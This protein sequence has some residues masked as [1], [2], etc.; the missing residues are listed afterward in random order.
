LYLFIFES[1]G[2]SELILIAIVSLI[3]LGPRKMPQMARKIGKMMSDFRNATSEFKTTWEREVNFED[4]T[5]AFRTGTIDDE[6]KP[7]PRVDSIAAPAP[8]DA[9]AS[10]EVTEVDPA[11][12]DQ[13]RVSET[14]ASNSPKANS[15]K[16]DVDALA[17]KQNWL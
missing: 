7:V 14:A 16:E 8:I 10:P 15:D 12:F 11:V 17:E 6:V 3:F 2:T 9:I 5:R 4:E 13:S 1:I